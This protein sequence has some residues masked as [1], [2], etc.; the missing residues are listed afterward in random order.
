MKKH[1]LAIAF[2]ILI[3]AGGAFAQTVEQQVAR[4][5]QIAGATNTEIDAGLKDKTSG[6]HYA[7]WTVG[8]A[9]DG[10]QWGGVGTMQTSDEYYF[11]CEPE[12][13][14]ICD[15]EDVRTLV[16]KIVSSYKGAADLRTKSEY[17]FEEKTGELV[18]AFTSELEADGKTTERRFYFGK[19]KLI[20]LTQAGKNTD[21][22]FSAEDLEKADDEMQSA[23]SLRETFARMFS[24][25]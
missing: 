6:L 22:K 10:Q 17:F 19:D 21:A 4:I 20:R 13:L 18:F 25:D 12:R 1:V 8:G 2:L 24:S 23:K 7:A 14:E 15:T 9:R 5:R 3:Q 11:E 16:R